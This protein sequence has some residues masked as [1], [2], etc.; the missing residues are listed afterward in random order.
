MNNQYAGMHTSQRDNPGACGGRG[1]APPYAPFQRDNA[2]AYGGGGVCTS[3]CPMT[4]S[5]HKA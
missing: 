2:G 5:C 3:L 4:D 1:F